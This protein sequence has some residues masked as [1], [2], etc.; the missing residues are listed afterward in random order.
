MFQSPDLNHSLPSFSDGFDDSLC[1][2]RYFSNFSQSSCCFFN[3]MAPTL[4]HWSSIVASF[5]PFLLDFLICLCLAIFLT[6]LIFFLSTVHS[7]TQRRQV[8]IITLLWYRFRL[9][10]SNSI[11]QYWSLSFMQP[12]A[13][14][15]VETIVYSRCA[16]IY[17]TL[18]KFML[19]TLY[20][21]FIDI[22]IFEQPEA[23][24]IKIIQNKIIGTNKII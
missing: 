8:K 24:N 14:D 12:F 11:F 19:G 9:R 17:N 3:F 22:L 13:W 7:L 18:C 20:L 16:Y 6:L 4:I 10:T 2:H 21:N 23:K 5:I 1:V 15:T